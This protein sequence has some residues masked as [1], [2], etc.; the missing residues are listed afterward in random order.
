VQGGN[1]GPD[2][3]P[4]QVGTDQFISFTAGIDG[5]FLP[6]AGTMGGGVMPCVESGIQAASKVGTYLKH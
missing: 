2:Q 6:G 3:T 4:D 1:Y 5:L